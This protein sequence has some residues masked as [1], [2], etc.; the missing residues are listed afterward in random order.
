MPATQPL[1]PA[2]STPTRIEPSTQSQPAST[3][4]ASNAFQPPATPAAPSTPSTPLPTPLRP[5]SPRPLPS[6]SPL[7]SRSLF[8]SPLGPSRQV[9]SLIRGYGL[10]N[11]PEVL[12]YLETIVQQ[13]TQGLKNQEAI[14]DKIDALIAVLSGTSEFVEAR[15]SPPTPNLARPITEL[16]L[17]NGSTPQHPPQAPA[18]TTPLNTEVPLDDKIFCSRQKASS[19]KNFAVLLVRKLFEPHELD[20]RNVRGIGKPALDIE[21]VQTIQELVYKHYPTPSTQW[22]SLWHDCRQAVDT[23]LRNRKLGKRSH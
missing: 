14:M 20:G 21:K 2:P 1:Q 6:R 15:P 10:T 16:E 23:F 8:A 9:P 11:Q 18:V 4:T 3:P 5:A 12:G 22:E 19:A 17:V 13:N 7:V